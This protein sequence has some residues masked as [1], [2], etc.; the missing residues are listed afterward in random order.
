MS[1]KASGVSNEAVLAKTG[2]S[3]EQ[4]FVILDGIDATKMSHKA[5]ASWLNEHHAEIGAWWAQSI[6]VAFEK[7]RGMRDE[8]QKSDDYAVSASRTIAVGV[9]K[10]FEAVASEQLRAGWLD[11]A[12]VVRKATPNKSMRI[13]WSDGAS[14]V[15]VNFY[16][17][18]ADKSQIALEHEKLPD[19]DSAAAIKIYW[20][21]AL[22]RL[23]ALLLT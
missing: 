22:D 19:A 21:E 5:I 12:I 10:L 14:S 4:W 15:N 6:T 16:A 2:L 1:D 23:K 13:T 3:W 11:E 8:N 20:G 17:K 18:G 7:A 9:E